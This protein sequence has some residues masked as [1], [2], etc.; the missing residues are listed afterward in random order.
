M[1]FNYYIAIQFYYCFFIFFIYTFEY[2]VE[3]AYSILPYKK[4]L[5]NS[6]I[7]L[8]YRIKSSYGFDSQWFASFKYY[9]KDKI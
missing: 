9:N 7:F 5:P 6:L 1:N 2:V 4:D 3:I 8:L